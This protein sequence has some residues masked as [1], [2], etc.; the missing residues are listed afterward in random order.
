MNGEVRTRS[1]CK[2]IQK[3]FIIQRCGNF[4]SDAFPSVLAG[5]VGTCSTLSQETVAIYTTHAWEAST[6]HA[7]EFVLGVRISSDLEHAEQCKS[8]CK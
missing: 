4:K 7:R 6:G 2:I 3:C 1:D 5:V 8:A